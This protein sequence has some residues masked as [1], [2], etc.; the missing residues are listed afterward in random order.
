MPDINPAIEL[1]ERPTASEVFMIAGWHQWADAGNVSS[2]L[3]QYLIELTEARRIGF[4]RD[5]GFY[6]FQVPGTHHF[7]RPEIKLQDGYRQ[8]M[9]AYVNEFHYAET[10]GKGLVIFLGHEPHLRALHY[11]EAL[12]DGI[13]A[14]GVRR[15]VALGGV[16]GALPYRRDRHIHCVYSLWG[17]KQELERY[18][19]IF[20]NYEGGSTI[21][22]YLVDRA[23]RRGVEVVDLYAFVPAYDFSELSQTVPGLRIDNDFKAWYDIMLRVNHMFGLGLDLSELERRSAALIAA[24]DQQI[25]EL[26]RQTPVLRLRELLDRLDREFTEVSFNALDDA[27]EQ[28]LGDLL[29][30][31][32]A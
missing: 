13:Q 30:D 19:L 10:N 3:P 12:L 32:E 22:T 5:E 4:L 29:S 21:G 2:R 15:V 26:E 14:L 18:G 6:L 11:V 16:Y 17:M 8:S 20:S 23:E 25:A 31:I 24:M 28:E 7:L 9:E 27:L 1:W